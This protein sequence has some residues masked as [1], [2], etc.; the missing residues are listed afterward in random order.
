MSDHEFWSL[1]GDDL[2]GDPMDLKLNRKLRRQL[3]GSHICF[4]SKGGGSAPSPDP[5]I[6]RAALKQAETGQ[7]WLE[8]AREQFGEANKRQEGIDAL[9]RQVTEAQLDSM[10]S[11]NQ[12]ADEMWKRYQEVFKPAQDEF[13]AEASNWA[14]PERQAEVAAEAK[15]DVMANAA[16]AQGQNQRAMASMGVSPT[17]G[18]YAG[19]DRAN[20]TNTALAAA[21]AQ[22][23][24][25]NQVRTQGLALKEGIAN[26]GQGATS[27]SAQQ[28]GLGL[29]SGNS[30]VGNI[31][32]AN[33]QFLQGTNIMG[34]GFQGAMQ[35]YAGQAG[36]LN[37]QYQNQLAG[38]H[39][40]QQANAGMWQG[41]GS[42]VGSGTALYAMGAF[43]SKEVKE[44]KQ[45][46]D[47]ALEALERMPVEKWKYKDGVAD[48]GEHIGPYA[49][50]FQ[51]ATGVG[52]GTMIPFQDAIGVTM[53]A[54]QELNQKVDKLAG[55]KHALA[56]GL[57]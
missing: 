37:Q 54:V 31:G 20:A 23:Q 27:T 48:S 5:Q 32:A 45:P 21:G 57:A 50:D 19:I 47:G 17:S 39:A 34:Q 25:R 43:S 29:N 4:G 8:F 30:A 44:D 52:D 13:I 16:A 42:L 10:T 56:G 6:G 2:L 38:Y 41:I 55:K 24:A 7:Q 26:M 22:N 46:V 12:R 36:T 35:G 3:L 1:P 9:T 15:A 40:D 33:S 53:K 51:A 14:S 18:R 28:V 49:E 11:S